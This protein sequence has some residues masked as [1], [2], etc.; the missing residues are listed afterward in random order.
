LVYVYWQCSCKRIYYYLTEHA[1]E[2]FTDICPQAE[3]VYEA[4]TKLGLFLSKHQRSL[5]NVDTLTGRPWW[6]AEQTT[7]ANELKVRAEYCR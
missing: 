3:A 4:G 6:T 2:L 7:H 1:S 5:Y